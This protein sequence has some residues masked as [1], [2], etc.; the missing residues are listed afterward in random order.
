[1]A[2][3]DQDQLLLLLLGRLAQL[4]GLGRDLLLVQLAR[5]GNRQPLAHRHRAGARHQAG[6]AR[7]HQRA[8]RRGRTRNAHHQAEVGH[9]PV[10]GAQHRRPQCVAATAMAALEHRQLRAAQPALARDRAHDAGVRALVGWQAG[11]LRLSLVVVGA[12]VA[13][14]GRGQ[15]R[16]HEAGPEAARRP[17][18]QAG[19]QGRRQRASLV[20][21]AAAPELGM[22]LLDRGEAAKNLGELGIGFAVA[23][24][25]VDGGP[26]DFSLQVGPITLRVFIVH[27]SAEPKA[28]K[29]RWRRTG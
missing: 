27:R 4:V 22:R 26:V 21:E 19:M 25:T 2:L 23:Q 13:G 29:A 15:G 11:A 12:A 14:L 9:Q 1:L 16:D 7:Q 6:K 24:G 5:T 28:I 3:V 17:G 18:E 20:V 10:I 8:F